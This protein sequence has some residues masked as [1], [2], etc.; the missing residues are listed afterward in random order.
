MNWDFALLLGLPACAFVTWAVWV[1]K[2]T[3][4]KK[5][6]SSFAM[7]AGRRKARIWLIAAIAMTV[8]AAV[9]CFFLIRGMNTPTAG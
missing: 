2:L 6:W 3:N 8:L 9:V 5:A 7:F 1:V 4:S